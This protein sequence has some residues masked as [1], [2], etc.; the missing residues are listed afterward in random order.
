[1]RIL[2]VLQTLRAGGAQR[3]FS[4]MAEEWIAE[5]HEVSLLLFTSDSESDFTPVHPEV[6]IHHLG[7]L[8]ACGGGL[9]QR[10]VKNM[11][12]FPVMRKAV[13]DLNPDCVLGLMI[14]ENL[15]LRLSTL[16]MRIPIIL[17]EHSPYSYDPGYLKRLLRDLVYPLAEGVVMLT[18]Q[19]KHHAVGSIR[20]KTLVIENPINPPKSVLTSGGGN[21]ATEANKEQGGVFIA[22]GR[23]VAQKRFDRFIRAF[24]LIA[25][26]CKGW[27]VYL[28]GSG[29]EEASLQNLICGLGLQKRAILKG[30]VKEPWEALLEADVFVMSSDTE[31]FPMALIEAMTCGLAVI[32]TDCPTG[33]GELIVDSENGILVPM[34]EEALADA[35]RR[36]A[37]DPT[38]RD[39]LGREAVKIRERLGTE[40][41]MER[42]NRFLANCV[43]SNDD[44]ARV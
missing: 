41:I 42:Y 3:V 1:M 8:G 36:L 19:A 31:G 33:P 11:R 18:R 44:A 12:R 43:R 24:S 26:R 25:D 27:Q 14:D 20:D 21:T 23:L 16:G 5:G 40:R 7:I 39:K 9:F 10:I 22:I 30:P 13:R 2:C 15:V 4:L 17:V 6:D 34:S 35:M 29:E 32:S 37:L 28:Y 38:L